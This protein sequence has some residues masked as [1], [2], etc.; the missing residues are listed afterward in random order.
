MRIAERRVKSKRQGSRLSLSSTLT[1]LLWRKMSSRKVEFEQITLF[2]SYPL[3]S[4][5]F[6]HLLFLLFLYFSLLLSSL[7]LVFFTISIAPMCWSPKRKSSMF[8]TLCVTTF[9]LSITSNPSRHSPFLFLFVCL[10]VSP[11]SIEIWE[12]KWHFSKESRRYCKQIHRLLY[13]LEVPVC[14]VYTWFPSIKPPKKS[15]VFYLLLICFC[16]FKHQLLSPLW[17]IYS[18]V[19][20]QF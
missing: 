13:W 1:V 11:V 3:L 14:V 18:F 7:F 15:A 4:H 2:F 19:F 17:V 12:V 20:N 5:T 9:Y 6:L 16:N 10:F 8:F